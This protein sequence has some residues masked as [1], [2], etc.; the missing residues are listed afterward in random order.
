MCS[1]NSLSICTQVASCFKLG[2][3]SVGIILSGR[4]PIEL[5]S[6]AN[7]V[8]NTLTGNGQAYSTQLIIMDWSSCAEPVS[9]LSLAA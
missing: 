4:Q 8:S 6:C 9:D 3:C 7:C 1:D 2:L 5:G